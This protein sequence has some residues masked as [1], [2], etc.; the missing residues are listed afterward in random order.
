MQDNGAR[1]LSL[2]IGDKNYSSWSLRPWLAMRAFRIPFAEIA[3]R[4]RQEDTKAQILRHSPSGKAPVLIVGAT[5]VWDSLA[6]AETLAELH[7]DK[8]LWPSGAEARAH[9]RAISA[10]MHA[11]FAD[12]RRDLP[13]DWT[14]RLPPPPVHAPLAG[15]IAR[16]VAIISD[17]RARFGGGGVFLFGDFSIADAMYAPVATRFVTYGIKLDPVSQAYVDTIMAMPAVK[18]WARAA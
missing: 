10:E 1:R 15:D 17:A 9:A 8:A 18:E 2:V 5:P 4:L 7:P 3:I 12:L 11:G 6:I 14:G 16:I 13:M